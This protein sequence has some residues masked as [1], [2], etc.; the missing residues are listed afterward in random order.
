MVDQVGTIFGQIDHHQDT[1][2]V[3]ACAILILV[4]EEL[5]VL[6]NG[7]PF[8]VSDHIQTELDAILIGDG[9]KS[10]AVQRGQIVSVQKFGCIIDQAIFLSRQRGAGKANGHDQGN[11][12][13]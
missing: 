1:V 4:V 2:M 3:R 9:L 5:G 8:Q 7:I 12:E 13:R 10:L 6:V 11:Q